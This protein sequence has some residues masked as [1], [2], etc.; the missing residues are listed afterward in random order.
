MDYKISPDFDYTLQKKVYEY[1]ANDKKNNGYWS[2]KEVCLKIDEKY[3]ITAALDAR[4]IIL[5][6]ICNIPDEEKYINDC[7]NSAKTQKISRRI[8]SKHSKMDMVDY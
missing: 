4:E 6:N 8:I 2:L 7:I 5:K 3:G 1:M